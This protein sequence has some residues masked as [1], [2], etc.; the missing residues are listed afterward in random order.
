MIDSNTEDFTLIS[1]IKDNADSDALNLLISRHSGICYKIYNKYFSNN[2]SSFARDI[3][4]QKDS[5]IY[6]AVKTFNPD[7]GTKFS[8]W[9]GNVVTYACLNACN[10]NKKEILFDEDISKYLSD[11]HS[12]EQSALIMKDKEMLQHIEDIIEM[13]SD[14]TAKEVIKMRYLS[15]TQKVKTFKEIADHFG[16]STQTVVN[17]HDKFLEFLRNKLKS[18]TIID[19]V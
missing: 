1:K 9:L 11:S 6:Q 17:W 12:S 15:N 7:F 8:T 10:A 19:I 18:N 16:V 13:S 2:S 3:E 4:E 5:L 14:E